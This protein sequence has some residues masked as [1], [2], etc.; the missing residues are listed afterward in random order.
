MVCAL[1]RMSL[2][3]LSQ[4]FS[5]LQ[6]FSEHPGQGYNLWGLLALSTNIVQCL[7]HGPLACISWLMS[8]APPE[9]RPGGLAGH[10]AFFSGVV[11]HR[12]TQKGAWNLVGC[13]EISVGPVEGFELL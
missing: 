5:S 8:G 1:P 3:G 13:Q 10:F 12:P 6:A 4:A 11:P 7:I 2:P 9:W